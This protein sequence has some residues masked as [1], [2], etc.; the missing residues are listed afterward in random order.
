M[1][2]AVIGYEDLLRLAAME[3]RVYRLRCGEG[4]SMVIP[5]LGFSLYDSFSPPVLAW[6]DLSPSGGL[7][8]TEIVVWGQAGPCSAA[9]PLLLA[10]QI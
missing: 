1:K 4:W 10:D 8:W 2:P 7:V 5:W 9:G 3:E 6:P